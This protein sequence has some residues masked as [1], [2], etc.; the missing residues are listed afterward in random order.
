M[1]FEQKPVY[2]EDQVLTTRDLLA[3]RNG[4]ALQFEQLS[5]YRIMDRYKFLAFF[6]CID[7]L[8]KWLEAGKPDTFKGAYNEESGEIEP[9]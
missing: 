2:E 6:T 1:T 3:V 5:K 4:F 7:L 8:L 9:R